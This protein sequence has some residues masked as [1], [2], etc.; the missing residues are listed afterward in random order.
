MKDL[1]LRRLTNFQFFAVYHLSGVVLLCG[2]MVLS[3]V[4]VLILYNKSD[5]KHPTSPRVQIF[6]L[7]LGKLFCYKVQ[8]SK[9]VIPTR[10]EV[11]EFQSDDDKPDEDKN[12]Q[13][14]KPQG[15][16]DDFSKEELCCCWKDAAR[17]LDKT[18][19]AVYSSSVFIL[20][21]IVAYLVQ[22]QEI[23]TRHCS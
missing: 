6:F 5:K 14:T 16:N 3:T 7:V 23:P 13:E 17:I 4:I 21:V 18:F 15:V 9:G 22:V 19:F 10:I 2:A 1:H 12:E 11:K 8:L 20:S